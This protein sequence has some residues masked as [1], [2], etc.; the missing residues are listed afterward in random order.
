[1]STRLFVTN[2]AGF[3]FAGTGSFLRRQ[4]DVYRGERLGIGS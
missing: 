4:P 2:G 1:M 3:S